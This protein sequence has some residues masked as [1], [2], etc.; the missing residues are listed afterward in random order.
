MLG[1]SMPHTIAVG[2]RL[3]HLENFASQWASGVDI[4]ADTDHLC[5]KSLFTRYLQLSPPLPHYLAK[6]PSFAACTP[7]GIVILH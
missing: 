4:H 5:E 2:C 1:V 6:F 3:V 7:A